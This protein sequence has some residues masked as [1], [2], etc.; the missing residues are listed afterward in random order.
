MRWLA[1]VTLVAGASLIACGD[2]EDDNGKNSAGSGGATGGTGGGVTGG[3]AGEQTGGTG[4]EETGGSGGGVTG[5]SGGGVTGGTGG[6]ET[7]GTG[8]GE[9]GGTGG[10]AGA[11]GS[12]GQGGG[13]GEINPCVLKCISDHPA[14]WKAL[15]DLMAPCVC[16]KGVCDDVCETSFCADPIDYEPPA[17]CASCALAKGESTC[18]AEVVQCLGDSNCSSIL[19]CLLACK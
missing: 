5:G 4:G 10:G 14:E 8:G 15:V 19:T 9:T 3:T 2:D 7:G 17:D 12:A 13:G 1:I 6:G 18:Q 16:E 11:A